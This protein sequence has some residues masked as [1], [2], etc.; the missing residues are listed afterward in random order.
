MKLA[1]TLE[2]LALDSNLIPCLFLVLQ[3]V[4]FTGRSPPPPSHLGHPPAST[5][6]QLKPP[7]LWGAS[8]ITQMKAVPLLALSTVD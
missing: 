4:T 2:Y 1:D 7:C 8:L 3:A 5:R 6:L